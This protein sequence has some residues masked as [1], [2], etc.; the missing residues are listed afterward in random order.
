MCSSPQY[1]VDECVSGL[2]FSENDAEETAVCLC[3]SS[4]VHSE[5][6]DNVVDKITWDRDIPADILDKIEG[7]LVPADSVTVWIDPLDAT[8]EYTGVHAAEVHWMK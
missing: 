3:D 6:H 5:E 8:Q 1:I 4:Q 7:K 2:H